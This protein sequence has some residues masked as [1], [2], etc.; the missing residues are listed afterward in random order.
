MQQSH[1]EMIRRCYGLDIHGISRHDLADH[2][3]AILI[4]EWYCDHG[5]LQASIAHWN[6]C[7][8]DFICAPV[9]R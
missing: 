4:L 8:V 1:D 2:R 9:T 6:M 5:P 7:Y 3:N